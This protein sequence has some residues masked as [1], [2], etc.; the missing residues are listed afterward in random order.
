[1]QTP[2]G[3]T[4]P[5]LVK[6]AHTT[7][8]QLWIHVII[9][10][11]KQVLA[12][13]YCPFGPL[14]LT[15]STWPSISVCCVLTWEFPTPAG[16]HK[17]QSPL[18]LLYL[19]LHFPHAFPITR[20]RCFTTTTHI[21]TQWTRNSYSMGIRIIG[22][23]PGPNLP[24]SYLKCFLLWSRQLQLTL[25]NNIFDMASLLL[26]APSISHSSTPHG[27]TWEQP[28]RPIW[29]SMLGTSRLEHTPA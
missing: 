17:P 21:L 7:W 24:P 11:L 6:W 20:V 28:S 4:F 5:P 14:A 16:Q 3:T 18:T 19:L 2:Q 29:G 12:C 13:K 10:G 23:S 15:F 25:N 26:D 22:L 9:L 27:A 8:W 1:M